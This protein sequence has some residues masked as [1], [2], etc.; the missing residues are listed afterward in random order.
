MIGIPYGSASL[1]MLLPISQASV[2]VER[3]LSAGQ[4]ALVAC[5][6]FLASARCES[7]GCSMDVILVL[8]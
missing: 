6:P 7:I 8:F 1:T 4:V 2:F 3:P 5:G